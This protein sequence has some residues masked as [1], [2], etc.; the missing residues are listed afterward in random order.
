M[1]ILFFIKSSTVDITNY[2]IKDIPGSSG[3]LDVISRCILA[4][5]LNQKGFNNNIQIWV[6][7]E[8]YG[9]F[10][11]D[12][13]SLDE[14][15]FPKNEILLTE[16]FVD[17]IQNKTGQ[18]KYN[19]NPLKSIKYN[20][21][22]IFNILKA[23]KKQNYAIYVLDE[24][25]QDFFKYIKEILSQEHI[26]FVIGSQTGEILKSKELIELNLTKLSLG[27][28]SYLASSVIRLIRLNLK[29]L[30]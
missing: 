30:I 27:T 1:E 19:K 3:R 28:F 14:E 21:Q 8:K 7:L 22:D 12:P 15:V 10:I 23:Y 29:L 2:T 24:S 4:A 17:L 20:N 16:Y 6:F 26:I 5:L 13:K 9:T 25:A 18:L 11:F